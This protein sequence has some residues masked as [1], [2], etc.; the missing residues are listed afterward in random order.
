MRSKQTGITFIGW[1]FL[2]IPLA[3]VGYA[4]IRLVPIYLNYTRV[5]RSMEQ[6]ASE[7]KAD[8]STGTV[9]PQAVKNSL[10]KRLD[11]EGIEYPDLKDFVIRR[12]GRGFFL[13]INYEDPVPF[14]ANVSLLVTF[15]KSVPIGNPGD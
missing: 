6:V 8:A 1:V 5:S 11:I 12:D 10:E 13:D 7:A 15:Q 14:I 3:V 2:L 4:A 9:N